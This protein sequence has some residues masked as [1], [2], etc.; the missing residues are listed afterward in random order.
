MQKLL[1]SMKA[2]TFLF[3]YINS[4]LHWKSN[5][6]S[7]HCQSTW[8]EVLVGCGNYYLILFFFL[9]CFSTSH[10]YLVARKWLPSSSAMQHFMIA[11]I[12]YLLISTVGCFLWILDLTTSWSKSV[13]I[14]ADMLMLPWLVCFVWFVS[15][16]ISFCPCCPFP[17]RVQRHLCV[18]GEGAHNESRSITEEDAVLACLAYFFFD[19]LSDFLVGIIFPYNGDVYWL[20]N[21]ILNGSRHLSIQKQRI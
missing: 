10:S 3:W 19:K 8:R 17:L 11:G 2:W 6:C 14:N 21:E 15:S 5:H 13:N 7:I 12:I 9:D 1:A 20:L 4:N 16:G 18:K